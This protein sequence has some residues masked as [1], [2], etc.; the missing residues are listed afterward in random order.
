[1]IRV[2]GIFFGM[3]QNDRWGECANL[4]AKPFYRAAIKLKR[5]ITEVHSLEI[6]PENASSLLAFGSPN[7]LNFFFRLIR[8][9]PEFSGFAAFA[10]GER[11]Y[12]G[13]P[14][15]FSD[16]SNRPGCSPNEVSGM[17]ADN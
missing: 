10:V 8:F 5:I 17:S 13:D 1:M 15:G 4:A 16:H 11:H 9:F 7:G 2:E 12:F 6:C 14:A 3:C